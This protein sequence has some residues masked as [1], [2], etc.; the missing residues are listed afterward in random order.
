MGIISRQL[1]E[2]M[3]LVRGKE[4]LKIT[5]LVRTGRS[6][7]AVVTNAKGKEERL[8]ISDMWNQKIS[9]QDPD[10]KMP[11]KTKAKAV[12]PTKKVLKPAKKEKAKKEKAPKMEPL[13]IKEVKRAN[14]VARHTFLKG[15]MPLY[16]SWQRTR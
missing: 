6:C 12:K 4:T 8:T 11:E 7:T 1:K 15:G 3:I 5:Q 13:L 2:K 10:K 16:S 14:G 9:I